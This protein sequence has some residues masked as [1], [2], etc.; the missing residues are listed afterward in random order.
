MSRTA[1]YALITLIILAAC[2]ALPARAQTCL[3]GACHQQI[4]AHKYLHGPV[5]AE[6]SGNHGCT[7]CHVP[8]GRECSQGK[9]GAFK[10]MAASTQ[11]CQTCHSKGTGTQHSAKKIDCLKCH[12]PHGS[13]RGIDLQRG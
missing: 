11:M 9:G 2:P 5:A 3:T 1:K 4:A 10:P 13:N 12:D 8:A 7:A 6:Q